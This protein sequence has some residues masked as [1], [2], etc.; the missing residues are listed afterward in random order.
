MHASRLNLDDF[1]DSPYAQELRR[2][3][4]ILGFESLLEHEYTAAHLQRVQ[5][6]VR[7]WFIF[8][9]LLALL[10]TAYSMQAAE[11]RAGSAVLHVLL[12][13]PC[14]LLLAV[15][16]WTPWYQQR[17]A[18]LAPP[19]IAV[20]CCLIALFSV[21]A[22][23]AG[24]ELQLTSM[25]VCLAA[26]FFFSGL[27]VRQ[28]LVLAVLA[29]LAFLFIAVRMHLPATLLTRSMLELVLTAGVAALV[30]CDVE[31][32][33]RRS[34]LEGALYGELAT[35]DGLSGLMNRRTFDLHL[36]R[37]WQHAARQHRTLALL[38][39]DIDHFKRFNDQYGHQTG[40]VALRRV[41]DIVRSVARRPLDMAARYGGEEFAVL[42]Y[43]LT[44]PHV[45][46]VAEKVCRNTRG[47]RLCSE[48]D[49]PLCQEAPTVSVGAVLL[50]P[51]PGPTAESAVSLA[52]E[53]LYE[54]KRLGR[55]RV[56]YRGAEE[57]PMEHS[58]VFSA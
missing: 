34:F 13:L 23:L 45:Q 18:H 8:A 42:L 49:N 51:A 37:V 40:D 4:G 19:L 36:Q 33:Y 10:F 32:A 26:L 17:Y 38:M 35:R 11:S 6:R 53:A 9:A 25:T 15:L 14:A 58:E 50:A 28:S 16:P 44:Y 7:T 56:V 21:Q 48:L 43:D 52:D 31:V 30:K 29:L 46:E 57:L 24:S 27:L 20:F 55:D 39:I 3:I 47:V 5:S 1:P 54:A 2:G 22:L 12:F 41:A